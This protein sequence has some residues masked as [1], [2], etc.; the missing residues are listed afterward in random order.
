[1]NTQTNG[2]AESYF[3]RPVPA[4][5]EIPVLQGIYWSL[6]REFWENRSLY[7]APLGFAALFLLASS[8]TTIHLHEMVSEALALEPARRH[9][10]IA[11]P[12]DQLGGLAMGILMLVGVFYCV[13]ALQRER[14]DRSILFWKSLPVSDLMT[15]LTKASIPLVVL[16]VLVFAITFATQ[17]IMVLAASTVLL[18]R[19]QDVSAYWAEVSLFRS[20]FLLL[21]HLITVHA[22]WAAPIFGWLFLV[23][24]W[25][26][27]SA[28]L[29][30]FL[31]P[32]AIA[33]LE[34]LW[35]NTAHFAS[36]LGR[37]FMVTPGT[38]AVTVPGAM[39]MHPMT[40]ITPLRFLATPDLWIGFAVTAV[41]LALA[42]R[43]RRYR[44]P[45]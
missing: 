7:L 33:A 16:P 42:V 41:F 15:V 3:E 18:V 36:F 31:P 22:L 24:A 10:R 14:R 8:F 1:M 9:A 21:Y 39:P 2:T 40:Q 28:L 19:G 23:S 38:D 11:A 29:W 6:Q 34:K 20:G 12:Y 25:A 30:A 17:A 32:V 43:L 45:N 35:F 13:E 5:V 37:R 26:R 44:G 27:R 4:D